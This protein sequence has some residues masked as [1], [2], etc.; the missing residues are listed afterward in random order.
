MTPLGH[1]RVMVDASRARG[2]TYGGIGGSRGRMG[3]RGKAK[4]GDWR[5]TGGVLPVN[6]RLTDRRHDHLAPGPLP[7]WRTVHS[8]ARSRV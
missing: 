3:G 1:L 2:S 8:R 4:M 5:G 7:R 6:G